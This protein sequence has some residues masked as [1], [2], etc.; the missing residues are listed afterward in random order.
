MWAGY[1]IT[2]VSLVGYIVLMAH[3]SESLERQQQVLGRDVLVAALA[4]ELLRRLQDAVGRRRELRR[5]HGL[6]HGRRHPVSASLTAVV[7]AARV[8]TCFPSVRGSAAIPRYR[9]G[10]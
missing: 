7:R 10:W 4:R 6:A 1:A 5:L 8:R 3:T 2:F 9:S